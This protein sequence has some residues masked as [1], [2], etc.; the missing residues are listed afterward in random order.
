VIRPS[1]RAALER[2]FRA[3]VLAADPAAGLRRE[4]LAQEGSL[5]L[6]GEVLAPGTPLLALAVGKAA[7][8]MARALD[9]IAG[10][11]VTA[12]L[13]IAKPGRAAAPPGW[14]ALEAAHPV[15]DATS[16]R[17]GRRA[18]RF[19]ADTPRDG[20][21][22]VL[23]SGGASS[24]MACP[25]DGL[26]LEDV[27]A[28]TR[29]LLA[30]GAAIDELNTV[31]KHVA[32]VAG[33][34]LAAA[35]GGARVCVLALSDVAGDRIDLIGSGPCAADPS[36]CADALAVLSRRVPE[37]RVP[38]AVWAHLRA[39]ARAELGASPLAAPTAPPRVRH[40]VLAGSATAVEGARAAA[41]C[42]GFAPIVVAREVSGEARR[43]G[44]RLAAL[45]A[46]LRP[47]RPVC[48]IAAGETTVTVRGAGRGGRSQELALSAAL[49]LAGD[50]AVTI[51]AAGT[52]G[53][54]GPTD[55]A[56]AFADGDTLAR[57]RAASLDARAALAANDA[58]GFFDREGGLL[59]TGP[60]GTNVRD[61]VLVSALPRGADGAVR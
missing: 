20:V 14:I 57:G 12:G 39:G 37:D 43:A 36:R 9:E 16:E 11:R 38:A 52:D 48:L 40:V 27:S 28:T 60:T 15:P 7:G 59:R 45:A 13:L 49:R 42:E 31:R 32:A 1:P 34:R 56:G 54:D 29:A 19:A 47:D 41:L 46:S 4:V 53:E 8:A 3:A 51:L 44:A 6:A 17:A 5:V 25:R 23:L 18:L 21:L 55:A 58:Y 35:A 24:L 50:P 61:L 10:R 22:L 30:E 2:I 26:S 33:G